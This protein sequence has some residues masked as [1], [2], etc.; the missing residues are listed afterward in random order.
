VEK[1]KKKPPPKPVGQKRKIPPLKISN[2]A[3]AK[4][5]KVSTNTKPKRGSKI[6][7]LEFDL[8]KMK[9]KSK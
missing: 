9:F 5:H 1:E 8:F 3:A 4:K 7:G 2:L 6:G